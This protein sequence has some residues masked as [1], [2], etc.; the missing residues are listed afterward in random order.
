MRVSRE[1]AAE[2]KARVIETAARL[3]RERGFRGV[4]VAD[5]MKAADLTHGGFYGQFESKDD[6]AHQACAAANAL[7]ADKWRALVKGAP[8]SALEALIDHYLARKHRDNPATGCAFAALAAD[9]AR[10]G[11]TMRATFTEGLAP[12]I[13]ILAAVMPG[14]SKAQRHR[15]ALARMSQLVGAVILARATGGQMSDDIL[16]AVR[17]DIL[18]R[19]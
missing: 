14:R 9:A 15:A 11:G 12:L 5:I 19:T 6:L 2:N 3:F 10:E 4:G 7:S 17:Q 13:D 1:Q 16:T 18:A 8:D